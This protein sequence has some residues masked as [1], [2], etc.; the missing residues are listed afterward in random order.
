[1]TFKNMDH[2]KLR[3]ATKR[4]DDKP[5]KKGSQQT[6]MMDSIFKLMFNKDEEFP[7]HSKTRST[8]LKDTRFSNTSG[9]KF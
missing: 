1:M 3:E 4:V 7:L 5:E 2:W 6:R 9:K 8:R